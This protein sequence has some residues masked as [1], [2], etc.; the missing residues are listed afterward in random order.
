MAQKQ[1]NIFLSA[2]IPEERKNSK[3]FNSAD[4]IAIRDA[5]IALVRVALPTYKLIWGGHP[6]ITKLVANVLAHSD[7]NIQSSVTLYQSLYYERFFPL[8]NNSVA[9]IITTPDL[10]EQESSEEELRERMIGENNFYAGVF[11]GGMEGVE[12]EFEIFIQKHPHAKV[13]PIA[14][15]GAAAKNIFDRISADP[16]LLNNLAYS[17][18]FKELLNL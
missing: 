8:E 14:S 5:V 16:R 9:N 17:S 11:I 18:L 12:K 2:S 4:V 3:Y 7:I 13:I 1:L 15:S 6:S 10:G